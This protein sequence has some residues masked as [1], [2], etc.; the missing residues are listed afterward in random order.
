MGATIEERNLRHI[1]Q[2][3]DATGCK[4]HDLSVEVNAT[5]EKQN[6]ANGMRGVHDAA[7]LTM[8]CHTFGRA[9][10]TRFALL[11]ELSVTSSGELYLRVAWIKTSSITQ[12]RVPGNNTAH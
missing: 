9:I 8:M 6:T 12:R 7:I 2:T 3:S 5:F 4:L 11:S 10:D 1:I